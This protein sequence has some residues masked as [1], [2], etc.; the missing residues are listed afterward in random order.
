MGPVKINEYI[1]TDP[2]ICHGKLTF[3]GTRVMLWQIFE[4]LAAGESLEEILDSYP[5]ITKEHI[6]AALIFVAER[7]S[8]KKFL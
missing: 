4:R 7:L 6:N 8:S 2:E 5:S 3:K 1:V